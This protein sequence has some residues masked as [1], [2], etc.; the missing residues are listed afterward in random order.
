MAQS[1]DIY[2]ANSNLLP[3]GWEDLATEVAGRYG[4]NFEVRFPQATRREALCAGILLRLVLGV[5]SDD[6]LIVGEFGKPR[7]TKGYPCFNLTDVD[8][9]S[10][11]AVASEEV[12]VDAETYRPR[13]GA[14]ERAAAER[15]LSQEE[16][17]ELDEAPE[18]QQPY[19]FIRMWT[20][21]EAK[22]KGDGR[23]FTVDPDYEEATRGWHV[24]TAD[25][26]NLCISCALRSDEP[27]IWLRPVSSEQLFDLLV[28]ESSTVYQP[29]RIDV[30]SDDF[31]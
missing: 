17:R 3:D 10:V 15:V 24:A 8:G 12:G 13:L 11:L 4:T 25:A 21:L 30:P 28:R 22:L 23:G 20:R 7:L 6:D 2:L 26:G 18:E 5:R 19:L 29:E 27:N 14:M 1:V 9:W 16:L 31:I